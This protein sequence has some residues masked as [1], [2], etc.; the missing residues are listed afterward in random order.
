MKNNNEKIRNFINKAKENNTSKKKSCKQTLAYKKK[1]KNLK[2]IK[3]LK[4]QAWLLNI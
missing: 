4:Q 2:L 3:I 1:L